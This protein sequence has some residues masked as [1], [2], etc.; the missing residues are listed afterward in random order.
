MKKK[1]SNNGEEDYLLFGEQGRFYA[2]LLDKYSEFVFSNKDEE[3]EFINCIKN[4]LNDNIDFETKIHIIRGLTMDVLLHK[5]IDKDTYVN[6][7]S[8]KH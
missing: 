4:T 6:Y 2:D 3:I 7:Y 1:D 5:T 8:K